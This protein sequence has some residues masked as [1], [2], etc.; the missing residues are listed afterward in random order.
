MAGKSITKPLVWILM[1]LLILG[2]GG[3]G[4][5]SLSGTLRT[6]GQVGE[7]DIS[8][9]DYFQGLQT[10]IRAEEASRR[11]SISFAQARAL[12]LDQLVLSQLIVQAAFDHETIISGLSVGDEN[13]RDTILGMRQFTGVDGAF[14]REAYRF[15][16]EQQGMNERQFE[17]D[18]RRDIARSFLQA[19][20]LA[21]VNMPESYT[22]TM[23]EYL[24]ERRSIEWSLLDRDDLD[25]G[26][27]VPTEADLVAYHTENPEAFTQPETKRISY[28]WLT[29]D[30][31][32]DTVEVDETALR[33]A[34]E[35][36]RGEFV[37]PERRLVE[38]LIYP[39][40]AAAEAA[41]ARVTD[42]E[43]TFEDLVAERGLELSDADLGVVAKTDLGD[44]AEPVFAAE[45]SQVVGPLTTGLGP[46]LFRVNAALA[47]Q[48]TP[49]EE[50]VPQLR[51]ALALDRARRVI[52]AEIE[53][54]DDLLAGGATV[55]DLA[56]ETDMQTGQIS[57]HPGMSDDIA[58]YEAFR[59][60]AAAITTDNYPE[61]AELEDGG[62]FAIRLDE[63]VPP[64]VQPLDTVREAVAAA[65]ENAQITAL[66]TEMVQPKVAQL[67]SG[68]GFADV[69]LE[70][71]GTQ[72]VTRRG[73][74]AE[75][76][77]SFI[78]TVF[79][80]QEGGVELVEGPGRV[81]VLKL[82]AIQGPDP[83]DPDLQEI[84]QFLENEAAGGVAQDL[85]QILANDIRTRAG[86]ELDEGALN[87]VHSNFQ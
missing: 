19:A 48:E 25:V 29:P 56:N 16:L 73:F 2:L 14:N 81:F 71:S 27:P 7:A 15:T 28:S 79:N 39:D 12:N 6:V 82:N 10:E 34:Y 20:V 36:R 1:G 40:Q 4:V 50:A 24:G 13:L 17:Q 75:A 18:T 59:A 32:I 49:F 11:E 35:A 21:G 5:T 58:A 38:R 67:E 72:E 60:A 51:D 57:W 80:M 3:F 41:L 43:A 42:G 37:Q 52:E 30:M 76:P 46:A 33:D 84:E 63:V 62:I 45:T 31:I 26:V 53:A 69:E 9:T 61:V 44:I 68:Q 47:A 86:V 85:F 87:A 70:V 54:V 23:V 78:E 55:E 64:T 74:I 83:E 66:L 22:D 65:W 8:V 77:A